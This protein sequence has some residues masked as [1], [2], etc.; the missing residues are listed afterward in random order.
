MKS[1]AALR[2]AGFTVAKASDA[3]DCTDI[4]SPTP[5][6]YYNPRFVEKPEQ[7]FNA[8]TQARALP[9]G[10]YALT[11]AGPYPGDDGYVSYGI[12]LKEDFDRAAFY[13]RRLEEHRAKVTQF[14][15]SFAEAVKQAIA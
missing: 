1:I 5:F 8:L 11:L 14:E 4:T 3:V 9:D 6:Y 13:F 7:I 12:V 15:G 2:A 10:G